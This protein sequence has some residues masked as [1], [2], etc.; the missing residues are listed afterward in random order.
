MQEQQQY[1][2]HNSE[3]MDLYF[4]K[5][6]MQS[7]SSSSRSIVCIIL[8]N[9]TPLL[10]SVRCRVALLQQQQYCLH[11]SEDIDSYFDQCEMQSG[12]SAEAV[13]FA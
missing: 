11:N 12:I 9:S 4:D 5:C 7:G 8:M 13:L 10:I 3:D 6:E 2:L 1:C